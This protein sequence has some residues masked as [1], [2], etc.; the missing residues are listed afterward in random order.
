[1][2][3]LTL[4]AVSIV[5]MRDLFAIVM[6]FGIYSLLSAGFFVDLDAV[7]VALTE[8][9]VGA[10][11][12][13]VLMLGTLA[14]TSRKEKTYSLGTLLPLAVVVVTGMAL[15][16]GTLDM[17]YF[18]DP[19][20]PIHGHVVPRY[21]EQSGEEIGIPNIVTSVLASYRGYDTLGETVVIFTA[22]VGVLTLLGGFAGRRRLK[23][24]NNMRHHIVL[25]VIAKA[26]IPLI[27]LYALYVQFH[28]D[29]SPGGGFQAG[30]IFASAFI[31]Y[32]IIF[33]LDTLERIV[34]PGV[35]RVLMATGVLIYGGTGVAAL[36][37]GGNYLDYN[38]LAHDPVHGQHLGIFLVELGVG[39]TV[40]AVMLSIFLNFTGRS[41]MSPD[42]K[43]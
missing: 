26:L 11:I 19:D 28:G 39:I 34:S 33:G 10:G 4:T 20:A 30:V 25:R 42:E 43:S 7:D 29:F 16:Y 31:L 8:A 40:S 38:V 22:G 27:L 21:I 3:L 15:I 32:T 14:M 23:P 35:L 17:P 36:L 2:S 6:L 37:L 13:T 5:F 1:M 41:T 12:T 24:S 18:S 9:A